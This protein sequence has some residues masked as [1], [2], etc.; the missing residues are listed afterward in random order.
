MV[1]WLRNNSDKG[2][3]KWSDFRLVSEM[4]KTEWEMGFGKR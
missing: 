3:K 4:Q 1:T 2:A